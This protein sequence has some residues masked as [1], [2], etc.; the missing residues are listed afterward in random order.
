MLH[1]AI[2]MQAKGKMLYAVS[3]VLVLVIY[4]G[5]NAWAVNQLE[6]DIDTSSILGNLEDV[7]L[8]SESTSLK[9]KV[10]FNNP[11][12]VP[13]LLL[14]T[15]FRMDY[16]EINIAQGQTKTMF[17]KPFSARNFTTEVNISN[18]AVK[19]TVFQ[20]GLDVLSGDSKSLETGFYMF[21]REIAKVE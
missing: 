7:E 5:L 19:D 10:N 4:A 12:V 2:L 6:A 17:L 14:P 8:S 20:A 16:G 13:V 1:Y 3:V 15:E 21:G 11:T 9:A 18:S